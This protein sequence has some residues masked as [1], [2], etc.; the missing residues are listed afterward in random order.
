MF[1][2]FVNI[3]FKNAFILTGILYRQLSSENNL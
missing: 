1:N 3:H 2:S